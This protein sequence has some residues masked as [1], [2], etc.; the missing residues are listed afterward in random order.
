VR[1]VAVVPIHAR[2]SVLGTVAIFTRTPRRFRADELALLQSIADQVGVALENA[3]LYEAELRRAAEL[4]QLNELKTEFVATVSHELRTPMTVVKTRFEALLRD[5]DRLA[6]ERRLE[7]L[8]V[9][10][11][12][13]DRLRRLLENLLLVSGIEDKRIQVRLAPVA[14]GPIVEEVVADLS[15][16]QARQIDSTLPA[17]LPPVRADRVRLGDVVSRLLENAIRYSAAPSAV[18]ISAERRNGSVVLSVRDR[19]IGISPEDMPR[20]FQ[21]FER[22]DRRIRSHTGTGLGLYISRRLVEG[23]GGQIWAES[24]LGS[25][26]SF[27]VRLAAENPAEVRA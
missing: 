26:S 4:E 1:S 17:D 27:H 23:M 3:R 13:A 22:I 7:Y 19:G 5:W 20:L 21:R 6:N 10:W 9:G 14:L 15:N 11:A 16:R 18:T 12:G 25:G 8:R 24:E 2:A